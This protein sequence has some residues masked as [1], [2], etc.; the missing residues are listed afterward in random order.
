MQ[1]F[2]LTQYSHHLNRDMHILVHGHTGMPLL[3][4]PCQDSMCDNFESFG[5]VD[6]LSDYIDGGRIQLF[7]VDTVDK[8]SWSDVFGDKGHRA[9]IQECYYHYIVDEAVPYI[10]EINGT[11]QLPI[12]LGCSLGATHAA[13]VFLRRPDLFS[14]MLAM[15]GCYDAPHFWDGWC[16]ETLYN[17]SPV[18]FLENMPADHYYIPM[19]NQKKIIFCVGQ[20]AWENEGIRTTK[21]IRDIFNR[22]GIHGWVDLW[23]YDV[24]HDWPW[25]KKQIRYFL[26]FLLD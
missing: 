6:L 26:P 25:W 9:W 16:D 18:H 7:T 19:Y 2:E 15:S 21:Q 13:I 4:F 22:K 5:M 20:G 10:M 24:N 1:R 8:E 17:N 14:G 23:G 11:G 12:P 3:V